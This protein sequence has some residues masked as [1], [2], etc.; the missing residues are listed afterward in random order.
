MAAEEASLRI[1]IDSMS[2]GLICDRLPASPTGNPSTTISGVFEPLSEL[3]PRMR[4]TAPAPGSC[5]VFMICNPA[6]RP[7]RRPS[8]DGAEMS[9][10]ASI[11]TETTDPV[12]SLFFIE[13]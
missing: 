5:D 6:A 7:C 13:P 9:L 11:F 12:R 10:M 4:T 2:D 3:L 8:T 1:S